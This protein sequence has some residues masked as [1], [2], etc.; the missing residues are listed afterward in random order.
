MPMNVK[1]MRQVQFADLIEFVAVAEDRSFTRA[2]GRL[3]VS[4]STLSQTIRAVEDRLGLRLLNRTTRHV[5]PTRAGER[6]LERLRPA[7]EGLELTLEEL[8]EYRDRP[9]GYLHLAIAPCWVR[10]WPASRRIILTS[11]SKSRPTMAPTISFLVISMR[12]FSWAVISLITWLQ[13]VSAE[14]SS[15]SSSVR[16]AISGSIRRR[17]RQQT[18]QN[19]IAF[20]SGLLREESIRGSLWAGVR[21]LASPSMALSSSM[22]WS[23]HSVRP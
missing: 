7:F 16:R 20:G 9:A 12:A 15:I 21:N 5:A 22:T 23:S 6:L 8:N 17:E 4:T 10:Y 14:R 19:T 11:R 18:C 2:A 3:G 13:C 1:R